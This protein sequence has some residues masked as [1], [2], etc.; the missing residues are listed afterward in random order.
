MAGGR[1]AGTRDLG[2]GGSPLGHAGVLR[3][4]LGMSA[5]SDGPGGFGVNEV[6]GGEWRIICFD[7]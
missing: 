3:E 5:T 6:R 4:H 2:Q 7:N 1:A